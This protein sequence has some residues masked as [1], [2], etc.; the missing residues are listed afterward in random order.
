MILWSIFLAT[1]GRGQIDNEEG[2]GK[3]EGSDIQ[4]CC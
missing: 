3:K 1:K 4:Q 2:F